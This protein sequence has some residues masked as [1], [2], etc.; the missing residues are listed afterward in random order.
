MYKL[1]YDKLMRTS[2]R[3]IKDKQDYPSKTDFGFW[4]MPTTHCRIRTAFWKTVQNAH[5]PMT[6]IASSV[7]LLSNFLLFLLPIALLSTLYLYLYPF[8]NRCSFRPAPFRLLTLADP[9]LEG[10]TSL[11]SDDLF[12]SFSAL[13]STVISLDP[14]SD[15]ITASLQHIQNLITSDLPASISYYRKRLDL[16]GNDYYLAH[17][18]RTLRFWTVPT[19]TVVLGDLLGSQWLSDEE[20]SKRA[21]RYWDRVFQGA[22]RVPDNITRTSARDDET[23]DETIEELGV[24]KAWRTRL[25]NVAGNHDIGYPSD[26]D[27]PLL[28]RFTHAFGPPN[29]SIRLRLR[30]PGFEDGSVSDVP[31]IPELRLVVLN[32]MNLDGP[33]RDA[34]A[35]TQTY[36]FL[37]SVIGTAREIKP[38]KGN[39]ATIVL[40]H[41]PLHKEAGVCVDGPWL[42]TGPTG[43]VE[44]QNHLSPGAGK[45]ILEG[46]FGLAGDGE[47]VPGGGRGRPGL[48]LNGHDHEGCDTLHSV[49]R[50]EEG[51]NTWNAQPWTNG[52]EWGQ[53]AE[54]PGVMREV[55][56]RSMMG[57]FGGNAG[58]ISAWFDFADREWRFDVQMC[59]AGV[60]HLW[61]AVHIMDLLVLLGVLLLGVLKLFLWARGSS[62]KRSGPKRLN[63]RRVGRQSNRKQ[64]SKTPR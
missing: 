43:V 38:E 40:T 29:W 55:T 41:I 45:T 47:G 50:G 19:H 36:G 21:G 13:R 42:K 5:T 53:P 14:I 46:I 16:L 64:G 48:V 24:D 22:Q 44:E 35:Q 2:L 10:S 59:Q 34:E 12:S 7:H 27:G 54:G 6:I 8:F 3:Y 33:A 18:Y 61:W 51:G 25:I 1:K 58:L 17:I 23:S 15:R 31:D 62:M 49:Q 37:N 57:D 28:K 39:A 4:R 30:P 26:V 9:Q 32:S 60:Q 20:F 11:P 52:S 56:V 63:K